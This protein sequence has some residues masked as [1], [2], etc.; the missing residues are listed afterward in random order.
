MLELNDD[1]FEV[2]FK[3]EVSR[4]KYPTIRDAKALRQSLK[5]K[6]ED[7]AMIDFIVTLGM[8]KEHAEDLTSQH[9]LAIM[10]GLNS[11]KK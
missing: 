11:K 8:K 1:L 3:G 2:K 7:E 10:E 6:P 4:L 5:D 9:L